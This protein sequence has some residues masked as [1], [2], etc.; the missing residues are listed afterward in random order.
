MFY[1]SIEEAVTQF[2]A[3]TLILKPEK[4]RYLRVYHYLKSS[5]RLIENKYMK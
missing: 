1:S 3:G 5:G 4:D 2:A